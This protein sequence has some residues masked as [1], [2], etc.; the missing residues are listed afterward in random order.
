MR[1]LFGMI[2]YSELREDRLALEIINEWY[3]FGERLFYIDSMGGGDSSFQRNG[4]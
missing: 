2:Q 4:V 3:V 1:T